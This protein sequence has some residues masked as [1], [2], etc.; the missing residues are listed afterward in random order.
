MGSG[1]ARGVVDLGV[2]AERLGRSGSDRRTELVVLGHHG[3]RVSSAAG[4]GH[5]GRGLVPVADLL[6][7]LGRHRRGRERTVDGLPGDG[8]ASGGEVDGDTVVVRPV[9]LEVV[10]LAEL[11]PG[12]VLRRRL[13][14]ADV[15]L[16]LVAGDAGALVVLRRGL[17]RL[18]PC[19]GL[20][21]DVQVDRGLE[22]SLHLLVV[23]C[24]DRDLARALGLS[25]RHRAGL[26]HHAVALVDEDR[27]VDRRPGLAG[28]RLDGGECGT[29]LGDLLGLLGHPLDVVADL[30]LALE[31]HALRRGVVPST[32]LV[33]TGLLASDTVAVGADGVV[34][35][36]E[37]VGSEHA[38]AGG[39][40]DDL[41]PDLGADGP[42]LAGSG[43]DLP[44]GHGLGLDV[45]V[46]PAS[47]LGLEL[48]RGDDVV[49]GL[50]RGLAVRGRRDDR[51]GAS[52]RDGRE[53]EQHSQ[54]GEH[55]DDAVDDAHYCSPFRKGVVRTKPSVSPLWGMTCY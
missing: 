17:S 40:V 27:V 5:L 11:H 26:D 6:T 24:G 19:R 38:L 4:L 22:L 20:P 15:A 44:A 45:E 49:G 39:G 23:A 55:R 14:L 46:E 18:A 1:G 12:R 34:P 36:L 54:H 2:D 48:G 10:E 28:L 51:L 50:E 53:T 41:V 21:L 29:G 42:L 8:A 13:G 9:D 25:L 33:A 43:L 7:T 30:D 35:S 52:R 47:G 3:D 37:T 16:R 32:H 31:A